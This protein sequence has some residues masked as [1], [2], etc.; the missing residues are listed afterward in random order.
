MN[1]DVNLNSLNPSYRIA[2]DVGGTFTDIALIDEN[3]SV[4]TKKSCPLPMIIQLPSL[5]EL[6]S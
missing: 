6:P 5:M 1:E 2:A 4:S 3:G